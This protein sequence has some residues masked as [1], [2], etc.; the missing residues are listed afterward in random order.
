MHANEIK[1][2]WMTFLEENSD[3]GALPN[4]PEQEV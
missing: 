4:W 3:I 1:A 2:R